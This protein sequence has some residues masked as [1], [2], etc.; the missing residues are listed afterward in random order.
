MRMV[1]GWF[2]LILSTAVLASAARADSACGYCP[3][4]GCGTAG[5]C[6]FNQATGDYSCSYYCVPGGSGCP[7]FACIYTHI[8]GEPYDS[9]ECG[10]C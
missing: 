9:W 1:A 7:P 5:G 4:T 6:A 2:L 3:V 8:E 10:G